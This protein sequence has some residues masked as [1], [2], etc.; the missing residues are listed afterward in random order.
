VRLTAQ[1]V[2]LELTQEKPGLNSL[3]KT[4]QPGLKNL[5]VN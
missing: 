5:R 1:L 2:R 3:R 4:L